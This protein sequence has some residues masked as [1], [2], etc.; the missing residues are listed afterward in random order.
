MIRSTDGERHLNESRD[1]GGG[2]SKVYFWTSVT[3]S[4]LLAFLLML[5]ADAAQDPLLFSQISAKKLLSYPHVPAEVIVKLRTARRGSVTKQEFSTLAGVSILELRAFETHD[6]FFKIRLQSQ[7][8]EQQALEKLRRHS[9]VEFAEP[10]Y[11]YHHT[12]LKEHGPLARTAGAPNDTEF[13]K[14]WGMVNTGQVD[15]AGS[16]GTPGA[17]IQVT[18]LWDQGIR[19]SRDL[20]VAVIDTGIE[21]GHP[22]LANNIYTNKGEI[23]GN[24]IDD[25]SNGFIDDIHGWDFSGDKADSNDDHRH[26]THCAGT[27][28][29]EG[30]NSRGVVGVNWNVSLLPVKFLDAS[31]SGTLENATKSIQYAT[32][33]RVKIMSNS[34]GGGGPSESLRDAIAEARDQGI[35]FVAAAGNDS[36]DNDTGP[37]YPSNY[38]LANVLSVAAINNRDQ[39]ASFSNWGKNTV[40]VAAP[41]VKIYSTVKGGGY[42]YLSGTS[43]ATPHVSGVAALIWSVRPELTYAELK[44]LLIRTSEPVST[45]RRKVVAKGRVSAFNALHQIVPPNTDPD[46]ALWKQVALVKESNHPYTNNEDSVIEVSRPGAKFIRVH[47]EKLEVESG[48]DFVTVESP[49]GEVIESFSGNATDVTSDYFRGD[50]VKIRLKSDYTMTKWG[51]KIDRIEVIM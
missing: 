20:L 26:G 39:L 21:W 27:I 8:D 18:R 29:A 25:D 5:R 47:F 40:H 1:T 36:S 33:M 38:P 32:K 4:T 22:D 7:G 34:W 46:E 37:H 15:G 48:Y 24:G 11:L 9:D 14:L 45:L 16:A 3:L 41:G 19:G 30:D 35:L 13:G 43:M 49:A 50:T 31:G 42:E 28:G 12:S 10:N 51:Y 2:P 6:R 17:D 44:D 23:A